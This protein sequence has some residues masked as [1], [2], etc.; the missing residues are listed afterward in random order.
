LTA[1]VSINKPPQGSLDGIDKTVVTYTVLS[2][3]FRKRP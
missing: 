1:K 3:K 2:R